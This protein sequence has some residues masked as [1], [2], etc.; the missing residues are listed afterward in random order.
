MNGKVSL[1]LPSSQC[2]EEKF[3]ISGTIYNVHKIKTNEWLRKS[4]IIELSP[5]DPRKRTL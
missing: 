2:E 3:K 4:T 5:V 1:E